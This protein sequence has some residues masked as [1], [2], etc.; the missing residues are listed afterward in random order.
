MEFHFPTVF[1]TKSKT[2]RNTVA[3]RG[4]NG[5]LPPKLETT[6]EWRDRGPIRFS[7][8]RSFVAALQGL[9]FLLSP[10][11]HINCNNAVATKRSRS[12]ASM[13]PTDRAVTSD[14]DA[15][16]HG[17]SPAH[18]NHN[19]DLGRSAAQARGR[20]LVRPLKRG[21]RESDQQKGQ[22]LNLGQSC[23]SSLGLIPESSDSLAWGIER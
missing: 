8:H 6:Q 11:R 15:G 22:I 13:M 19:T 12:A 16:G 7:N 14:T 1:E 3:I 9:Y 20:S 5:D 4:S 23:P 18:L 17:W 21:A 2:G 10:H